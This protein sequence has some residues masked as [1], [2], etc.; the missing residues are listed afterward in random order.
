[1]LQLFVT[2]PQ[3]MAVVSFLLR[4]GLFFIVPQIIID[5]SSPRTMTDFFFLPD[6]G[7]FLYIPRQR[8]FFNFIPDNRLQASAVFSP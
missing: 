4:Q 3:T 8:L 5:F 7:G 1:M 2:Y 6:N